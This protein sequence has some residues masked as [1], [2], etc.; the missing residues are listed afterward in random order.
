MT[1]NDS[2]DRDYEFHFIDEETIRLVVFDS[3]RTFG[4]ISY[5]FVM[6]RTVEE[7]GP[8]D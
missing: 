7:E 3:K 8:D 2:K 6:K 1:S 5:Y 4:D